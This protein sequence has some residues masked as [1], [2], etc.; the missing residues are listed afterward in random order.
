MWGNYNTW[1]S[2]R[3]AF[4]HYCRRRLARCLQP[5]SGTTSTTVTSPSSKSTVLQTYI[6]T[7]AQSQKMTYS[8]KTDST[9]KGGK[10]S[11]K[12]RN[13][14][15]LARPSK[16]TRRLI[17]VGMQ[18]VSCSLVAA[19]CTNSCRQVDWVVLR[20]WE[21]GLRDWWVTASIY[22]AM[23]GNRIRLIGRLTYFDTVR[24]RMHCLRSSM[25]TIIDW[26]RQAYL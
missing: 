15:F 22:W 13:W 16:S 10:N 3:Q 21:A 17:S 11:V 23:P 6:Q 9:A 20:I 18:L 7:P 19:T 14:K 24:R 26:Q 12:L 2:T 5:Q 25:L 4:T 1:T 8:R